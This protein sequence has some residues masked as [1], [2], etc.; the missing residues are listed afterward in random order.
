MKQV[1]QNFKTGRLYLD[2]LPMPQLSP[3][4]VLV[5]T[6]FSLISSGTERSTV[7]VGQSSLIGKARQRPDLVAQVL[8]N[9]RREG[10]SATIT[11]VKTKLDSLKALGYSASG[12]V[13]ASMDT[14][15]IFRPGD[16]VACAGQDYASHAEFIS[17]PQNLI[18]RVPD[19]VSSEEAAFCTLGAIAMQGVRQAAPQ[20]GERVCVIGLGLL[21]QLTCQLLQANG[22][23]VFGVDL[24][25]RLVELAAAAGADFAM[26]RAAGN[27]HSSM[28]VFTKGY[29]F[30]AVII[31]AATTSNDPVELAGVISR[32][33]GRVVV[34]GAVRMDIPRDPHFYR[35]ELELRMSCSYGPGRYDANYEERGVDYPLPYVRWSEQRN[36]EA[37][38]ELLAKRVVNVK[39]LITHTFEI[40]DAERAYEIV[41]GKVAEPSIGIL[42]RYSDATEKRSPTIQIHRKAIRDI[43]VGFVGA[44]SFAQSYLIPHVKALGASLDTVMTS[45]GLT[46]KNVAQKFG[47]RQCTSDIHSLLSNS[48][49]NSVFVATPHNCHSAQVVASLQAGKHVFVEKP[50]AVN[51]EQLASVISAKQH[52]AQTLMVGFNR[53]FAPLSQWAKQQFSGSAQPKMIHIRVNAGFIAKDHWTQIPEVGGGRIIG[54]VCHFIDLLQFFTNADPVRVHAECI[55]TDN[56]RMTPEDNVVIVVRLSDGSVGTI[57]YFANGDKAL[58]K[59]HIEIFGAGKV[60]II[61]NFIS[62]SLVAG[63][64]IKSV[65]MPGK[66]HKE[67]VA[68]FFDAIRSGA[69]S[70]ISFRS[71]CLTTYATFRVIDSLKTGLPQNVEL[72]V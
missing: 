50:L 39:S 48:D 61:D 35:K 67:E 43:N 45:R 7:K 30:D 36:M 47:F 21:G 68:A 15:G 63:S 2:E 40:D 12:R 31:T 17:V 25:N 37:F 70:P 49:I 46:S 16:R 22:C 4:M 3:G 24:S 23:K 53:R 60:V 62:G 26:N 55:A 19:E 14:E 32:K 8:Q 52:S 41:S 10:L 72:Y 51:D 11:K 66:G 28:D 71:V 65:K 13:V 29:G 27:L 38:L 33:K 18:A 64:K 69:G 9:V 34:V 5:E 54:E 1:I 20:L 57:S 42:L 56:S 44:G 58:P 59:E 6:E